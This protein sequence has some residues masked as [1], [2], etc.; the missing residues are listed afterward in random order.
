MSD[1][2][3]DIAAR[4]SAAP[5]C[6]WASSYSVSSPGHADN[7]SPAEIT[8]G[9]LAKTSD[10]NPVYDAA[11][12]TCQSSYCHG[13]AWAVW[14]EPRDSAQAC[15]TCHGLPPEAPHPQSDRCYACH[16]DVVDANMHIIAPERH[17]DGV[18]DFVAGDCK[19]CHGSDQN[20]APPLDTLGN[21]SI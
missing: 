15:G 8:F 1:G 18:V 9:A 16:A 20:N 11:T 21:S 19:L 14:T 4:S 13:K 6:P 7:G 12:R 17:V 3:A 5:R 2:L 10:L